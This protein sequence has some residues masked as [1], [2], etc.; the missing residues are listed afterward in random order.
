[1]GGMICAWRKNRFGR[2]I[3]IPCIEVRDSFFFYVAPIVPVGTH[4]QLT[5]VE[6]PRFVERN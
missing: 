1:M 5:W 3:Q 4:I 2:W 6:D